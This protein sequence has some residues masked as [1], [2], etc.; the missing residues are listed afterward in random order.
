MEGSARGSE[1]AGRISQSSHINH[2]VVGETGSLRRCS[3]IRCPANF[4]SA[5]RICS[6]V[7]SAHAQPF[8]TG[9]IDQTKVIRQ[10][11]SQAPDRC[12]CE[13][14][15]IEEVTQAKQLLEHFEELEDSL[16]VM[17]ARAA[18]D[19]EDDDDTRMAEDD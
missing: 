19:E 6:R 18:N 13:V 11:L 12:H 1:I 16:P 14:E 9:K 3:H 4:G 7:V 2:G 10:S 5:R 15:P 17:T 8:A